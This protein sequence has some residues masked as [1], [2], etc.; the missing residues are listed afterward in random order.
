VAK[1]YGVVHGKRGFPERWTFYI[2][3]DGVL[4]AI[5]RGVQAG[6]AGADLAKKLAELNVPKR[7]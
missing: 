7:K 1:A 6:T 5:D 2:D 3:P 4:R